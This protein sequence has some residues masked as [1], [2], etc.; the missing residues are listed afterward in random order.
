MKSH[1]VLY[2]IVLLSETLFSDIMHIKVNNGS[3]FEFDGVEHFQGISLPECAHFF[4]I[5]GLAI[6]HG[7]SNVTYN[8]VSN[9][10]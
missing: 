2:I 4:Y 10:R 8:K 6:W 1:I 3:H 9:G 5:N 7:F